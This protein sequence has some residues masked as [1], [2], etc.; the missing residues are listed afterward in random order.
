MTDRALVMGGGGVLGI[1]WM[2]GLTAAWKEAGVDLGSADLVV[3]T[4]AGS[5]VGTLLRYGV[6]PAQLTHLVAAGMGLPP[7]AVAKVATGAGLTED[8]WVGLFQAPLGDVPWPEKPLRISAVDAETGEPVMWTNAS[9]IPLA[10][11]LASS[12]A[13]P[14]L[15]PTV[16][17]N[18]RR[19]VDGGAWSGT[20]ADQA[21][22]FRRVLIVAPMGGPK[23][24]RGHEMLQKERAALEADG[25][26]VLTV[27][28]DPA[29]LQVFGDNLMDPA[30]IFDAL[31]NGRRQGAEAALQVRSFWA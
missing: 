23:Y 9:G 6:D 31:E 22:G 21:A 12:C 27:L 26:R 15:L 2:V 29:T 30:R 5:V 1:A 14:G 4:S 8:E 10:R 20:H 16:L 3:G 13:V 24:P 18:G 25:S 19:Y 7:A 11:A 28:P 17:I